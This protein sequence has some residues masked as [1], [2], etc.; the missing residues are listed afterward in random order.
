MKFLKKDN[1]V[2]AGTKFT[3]ISQVIL[4]GILVAAVIAL[5]VWL[6][7]V[8]TLLKNMI[9]LILIVLLVYYL[10]WR[11]SS[12]K[13]WF[14]LSVAGILLVNFIL[15]FHIYPTIMKYQSGK[16]IAGHILKNKIPEQNIYM[17]DYHSSAFDFHFSGTPPEISARKAIRLSENLNDM[18]IITTKDKLDLFEYHNFTIEKEFPHY[19]VQSLTWKFLNPSTRESSLR[20]VFLVRIN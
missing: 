1:P 2:I 16:A 7:P 11:N 10:I 9:I 8:A 3:G 17:I 4:S 13:M 14:R 5:S 12:F 15:N 20:K 18:W 6:F 19:P